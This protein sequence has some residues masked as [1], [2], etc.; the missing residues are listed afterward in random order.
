MNE[1]EWFASWFDS[2][3]YPIL[4]QHRDYREAEGFISKLLQFLRPGPKTHFLDLACGRGRHSVFIHKHGHQVTGVDLSPDSIA[5]ASLNQKPGLDFRV[6]DMRKP[7]PATYNYILN[8]FTSFGYFNDQDDNLKVLQHVK[9]ALEPNGVFVLDFMNVEKVIPELVLSEEKELN[10]IHF[11]IRRSVQKG[12]IVKDIHIDNKKDTF[13]FQERVQALDQN[14]F[15]SFFKTV[16][17][18]VIEIWGDYSGNNFSAE[19]SPR[20]IYFCR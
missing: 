6:H 18:E 20:L 10:G 9:K 14:A 4:Y 2:P 8:L 7:F 16:G 3:F 19:R 1:Q 11:N 15:E 17:L 5:D 12:Y 13:H